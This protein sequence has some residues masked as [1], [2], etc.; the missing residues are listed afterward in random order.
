MGKCCPRNN[1][2]SKAF[3]WIQR[4]RITQMICNNR[5][6]Q[7]INSDHEPLLHNI[8]EKQECAFQEDSTLYD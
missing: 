3:E 7:L 4:N 1:R 5:V 2:S 6:I 8:S